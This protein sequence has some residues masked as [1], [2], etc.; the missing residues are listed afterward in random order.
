MKGNVLPLRIILSSITR[1]FSKRVMG[2]L[3]SGRGGK[4]PNAAES[5]SDVEEGYELI[6]WL[7]I[8]EKTSLCHSR[9]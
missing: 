4:L 8:M 3:F 9:R 6:T 7:V 5:P 1:T 2:N